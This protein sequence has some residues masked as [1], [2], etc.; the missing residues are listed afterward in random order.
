M[1]RVILLLILAA[2]VGGQAFG[3]RGNGNHGNKRQ[4]I[5]SVSLSNSTFTGGA[6][7]GT[8]VGTISVSMSP[9]TPAFSGT[10]TL[11]GGNATSFQIVG[12]NLET[13]GVLPAGTYSINLVATE[14]GT[15]GSPFTAVVSINGTNPPQAQAITSV[16]LSSS[17]FTGGAPSGTVV[18]TIS[19][20]MSPATPAF[21]GTLTLSGGNAASFQIVG[22]NLE[23]KGV[24]QAG[25]YVINIAA[26]QTG[27]TGSPFTAVM[28]IIGLPQTSPGPGPTG[29]VLP[30]YND[31]SAN[32]ANAGLL[33][34]GG[35]PNRTTICATVTPL[36]GG[37]DDFA[38]I[39][40]AID[41][42]PAGQV[43]QLAAGA[44][45][46]KQ[47]D[48]P[49]QIS[50]GITLRG[51]AN[52]NGSA[53]PYCQTSITVAD[54]A[55]AYTGGACGST[56]P[57]G[58][59]PNGGPAVIA[60]APIDPGYNYSWAQCGNNSTGLNCGAVALTADAIQG[61][62]TIK[63]SSTS[64]FSVGQW[65]LIDEASGAGW[66]ADPLNATTGFGSL[67]AASDWLSP[68]A[69][70]ATGR[71]LWA[72]SQNGGGWDFGSSLPS[73]AGSVGCWFS[74]CDRPTAELHKIASIGTGTLTFDDPLTVSFRQSHSAQ[75][76]A[77]LY[78]NQ[79]GVGTPI[80]FLQSAGLENISVLRGANGGV[81]MEFCAYCW[82]K[83]V[84]VGNW[85]G[86]GVKI[87]YS[88]RSELNNVY[89]HHC[90]NSV[91][92]GGE[93]PISLDEASTEI[94]IT[95]S[96]TAFAGKGMVARAGGAGSVVSYSYIDDTMYDDFSGIGDYWVDMGINASHYS[97]P[98]HVLFE[99]NWGDNLDNDHTHGNSMYMTFFRNLG[100]G[101]RAPFTDPSNGKTV[102][103]ATGTGWTCGGGNCSPAAPGPLRAAGPSAYNYWFAFLGNVLGVAGK[104]T[105]ANG[106]SYEGDWNGNRIFMLGWNDGP[107][108]QDPYMN[109]SKGSYVFRHGNFD[110]V[111][112]G[113]Q[114]DANTPNHAL[115]NSLYLTSAPTFFGGRTWPWVNPAGS[116]Q[117]YTLPAQS[118]FAA[119]TPLAQ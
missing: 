117:L 17:T 50:T 45:I 73:Q 111:T 62:T 51:G 26:T 4:A 9:A 85:Y 8:V 18:G 106:W 16:S 6:P 15:T 27:T 87:V 74:Y 54:G 31:A 22:T 61:Q 32:W 105:A 64:N 14:A 34:I 40:T 3:S 47:A 80:S 28:T 43:V 112:N 10:L 102:N 116:P 95:N 118:R 38:R 55:L 19:V 110:Y 93:Y 1:F 44:F 12:T 13:K 90:W 86:G 108:G 52:C 81:E 103:D 109:G 83:N 104:T 101:L 91:N 82:M 2:A 59:C 77:G 97:G 84:E 99:G 46:I 11:S 20:S 41:A 98:H 53:S 37:Q 21:S 48:L 72:K 69:G 66:V 49:I 70:P 60:M 24:L 92:N 94:L 63:V 35:I 115:P 67:W 23:T 5:A 75:V 100:A 114:W 119:G 29:S 7:S 88:A 39:Q 89:V 56:A 79:S 58:A 68:T 33:S 30:S 65:V 96:I 25:T 107:G 42:C 36:G 71:V 76:Y 57:G 78:N 113:V